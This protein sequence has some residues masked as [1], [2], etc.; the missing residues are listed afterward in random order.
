MT[1]KALVVE[2]EIFHLDSR[3]QQ[4]ELKM[5]VIPEFLFK[6]YVIRKKCY[7]LSQTNTTKRSCSHTLS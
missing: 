7:S 6:S 5:A 2:V 4:F 1:F 3:L